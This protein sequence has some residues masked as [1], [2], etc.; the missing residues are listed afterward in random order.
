KD[1][2]RRIRTLSLSEFPDQLAM[3]R[4]FDHPDPRRLD[5]LLAFRFPANGFGRE[6][7]VD[8]DRHSGLTLHFTNPERPPQTCRVFSWPATGM[9]YF[10]SVLPIEYIG[11]DTELQP[12]PLEQQR[13]WELYRHLTA[14]TQLA[15]AVCRLVASKILLF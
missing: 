9:R 11:N 13:V 15:P 4:F 3:A 6:V 7:K 8:G 2:H 14:H 5:D 12:R 10:Y 1:H